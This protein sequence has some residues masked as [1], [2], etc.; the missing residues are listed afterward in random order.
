MSHLIPNLNRLSW[1]VLLVFVCVSGILA[2]S[3]VDRTVY[4]TEDLIIVPG[5]VTSEGFAGL[6]SVLMQEVDDDGLYQNFTEQNS[7]YWIFTPVN[8]GASPEDTPSE[9]VDEEPT[10]PTEEN[11]V[12]DPVLDGDAIEPVE[13]NADDNETDTESG[14]DN[15]NET[16]ATDSNTEPVSVNFS[17]PLPAATKF[18]LAQFDESTDLTD[19]MQDV[20][21]DEVQLDTI[22]D[23]PE[24]EVSSE[25]DESDLDSE[26]DTTDGEEVGSTTDSGAD[27]SITA[28]E[29]VDETD[30]QTP[31]VVDFGGQSCASVAGC[32]AKSLV[33]DG[34]ALPE[35]T[36]GSVLDTVQLR[37]SLAAKAR[38]GSPLQR[39]TVAY[40]IDGINYVPATVIDVDGEIANSINGDFYLVSIDVPPY[41]NDLSLL[42]VRLTYEGVEADIE[43][44]YVDGVWLEVTSGSFYEE[45]DF[46]SSSDAIAY[47]RDLAVP[48][49]NEM[50]TPNLDVVLGETPTFN[51]EYEM[52]KNFFRRIFNSLFGENTFSVKQVRVRHT[53]YGF[54]DVPYTVEYHEGKAW[55]LALPESPQKMHPGKYEVVVTIDE[56]DTE[57]TDS[58]E[59][60]WGVLAINSTKT[61]YTPGEE[62]TFNLAALTDQGDTICDANLILAITAPDNTFYDVPVTPSGACGENNV[63]DIP[64]YIASFINTEQIGLYKINLEHRNKNGEVVHKAQDSFAVMEFVPYDI[65]RTAPTRIYPLSPYNVNLKITANRTFDGDIVERVPRGFVVD[66]VSGDFTISTLPTFTE[67]RWS[68]VSLEEGEVLNLSYRFDAPDISPYLYILGPL[69]MDGFKELRAWQIASDALSG[70]GWFT[71]TRTVAGTNLNNTASPLQWST[72][73]VDTY[74]YTHSTTTNSERVTLRQSGDYFLAVTLP[75]QRTDANNSRTRVGVQVRVNGVAIPEGLGQSGYVRNANGHAE[76]SSHANFLLTNITA[77]DYV[78]VYAQGLTTI[79]AGDVVN[80]TSQAGLYLEYMAST[81]TVFAATTTRTV[82]STSLNTTASALQWSET[83]QDTGFVHSN[84]VNPENITLSDA[85]VYSVQIAV[86]LAGSAAQQ[87]VLGRVLLNGVEVNGGQFAQGYQQSAANENDAESS[88]HWSGI[89]VAT[90]TNQILSITVEQEAVAGTVLVP[91]GNVGSIFI[92]KMPATD[93]FVA[94]G[95][96][97]VG[98]IDWSPVATSSVQW[99]TELAT[100]STFTHS[101]TSNSHQITV[102]EAG[103]YL[104]TFNG[105][106]TQTAAARSNNRISVQVGGVDV[107]G[108]QVKSNYIRNQNGHGT[109]SSALTYLL[110]SLATSSVITVS[111]F[112]EANNT[113]VNDSTDAMIMLWK[114]TDFN[115]RPDEPTL[116]NVPFDNVRFASTTPYFEFMSSDSDGTSDLQYEFEI[117]TTSDFAT[118]TVR[119]SGVDAGF[120]NVVDGGDTSPFTEANQIRFQLQA[121]DALTDLNTYY[122]RVRAKDVNGSNTFGDWSTTQSLTVDLAASNPYW[123]Q[124]AD[125][126]FA[127]DTL[128]GALSSGNNA[129]VVDATDNTEMLIAYGEGTVT[130]PR[131]RLWNGTV[132]GT[133]GSAVAVGGTINWVETAAGVT[134]DEY[135]LVTLDGSNASYAQI[136]QASTTSWGNQVLLASGIT[137]PAYR[138]IAVAYES[139]SGDAMAISCGTGPDPVYRIWNGSSW[140]GTSTIN[141]SSLNNCNYVTVASDPA[142]DEIIVIVRD[143]GTQYEAFV[144]D[145][146]G[147]VESRV[148]GASNSITR[149]GMSVVYEAS[150]DQAI[151]LSTNGTANS[152]V[153]TTWNGTEWGTNTTQGVGNDFAEARLTAD[154]DSDEIILCYVDIDNDIGVLRWDGGVWATTFSELETTAN[155]ST[156]R[157]FDC[158]FETS[159]GRSTYAATIYSDNAGVR[160]RTATS[161]TWAAEANVSTVLDSFWVQTERADNGIIMTAALDDD[162]FDDLAVSY[163]NGSSWST[164]EVLETNPSSVIATPYEMFDMSAKRYQFTQGTV[165][166]QPIDFDFVPNQPTWGDVTFGST[167]PFGTEVLV[168]LK[169]TASTACDTYI[170]GAALAGN[171]TGFDATSLPINL[172]SLS[173]TTYNQICLEASITTLGSASAS[174]DD[175]ALSWV[176]EPKPIQSSFRW[177]TNLSALTPTDPWPLGVTDLSELAVI[178]ASVPV[179]DGD[180]LRLRM[181]LLGSNV[182]MPTTTEAFKLQ[183]AQTSSC[184]LSSTWQDVGTVGSTTALWRGYSNSVVGTDWYSASWSRRTR[185]SVNRTLVATTSPITD[186]PVYVNLDDLPA[187]F[188][189]NVQSDGDDIRITTS[190]GVTEVPYELVSISTASDNGELHFKAPTLSTT[191]DTVFYIY[192]GNSGASGYAASATYGSQ[193]V[194]TNNYRTRQALDDSPAASSPQFR[195][196]TS[197]SNDAVAYGDMLAGS[198]VA[199]KIGSGTVMTGNDGGTFESAFAFPGEFSLSMWWL[200]TG[201]GFAMAGP[202]GANEKM[203]PWNTPAGQV[204]TRVLTTSDTSVVHPADGTWTHVVLTRDSANKVDLYLNGVRSRLYSDVAQSGVSDWINFGGDPTQGFIGTLDELR[205]ATGTRT[206][207]WVTTEYNNQ[208]NATG[209]YTIATEELIGDNRPL[210]STVL[211]NSDR[212]ETYEENNPTGQNNYAL[213]VDQESEWDFV[214]E[215]NG[216]SANTQYCFRLVYSDGAVLSDYLDY[217]LLVTNAPPQAPD[218]SAPFDNEQM[219][220]TSPWFE[221]SAADEAGDDVSYEIEIDD[222]YAFASPNITGDSNASFA[223]F[224]NVINPSERSVYSDGQTVRFVP[225][226]ALTTGVTYYWRVRAIDNDGSNT[227][228]LWSSVRSFTVNTGTTITTWYQTTGEQF[229]TNSHDNTVVSTS[230]DDVRIATSLT[231]GTTT[232]SVI[233]YDDR[234]TGNAWGSFSFSHNV[235]SGSIRYYVEYQV[236]SGEFALVPDT[237]LSGNSSGFTSSPISLAT[238]NPDTY[239]ELRLVAVL[240]GNDSLPRLLDW[241]VTWGLTIE[242]PA[243]SVPFD[244]AKVS[245]TTPTFNFVTSDPEGQDLEYEVQISSDSDF[246]SSSTFLSGVDAGFVNSENSG[247]TSPFTTNQVIAYTVQ[248]P[249]TNG[250]TYWWRARA[251]DPAGSNTW[252]D[253]SVPTSFTVDTAITTSVWYQTTGDQF[254]TDGLTDIE[255]TA[256]GAQITSVVRGM[257]MAYGEGTGQ[258]PR[259]RIFDGTQ[260]GAAETAESIGSTIRWT[261]LK[262][263][264][265][266]PEYALATIGSD[267]DSNVQIYD[268]S[269]DV[270]GNVKELDDTIADVSKKGIALSYESDSGDLLAVSCDG[271]D[272]VYSIWNGT[273][274]TA[275]TSLNLTN[276]NN[277]NWVEMASDPTSDEIVAVFR[278]TNAGANDAEA[279]VWSGSGWGNNLAYS[280]QEQDAY[281]GIAVAYEESGGQAVVVGANNAGLNLVYSTWN[282]T[283][284]LA[285]STA[286]GTVALGDHIEWASL[287]P[288][289]G[290][291]NIALC[292]IDNDSD[293]GIVQWNG[294]G[295]GTATELEQLG[296]SNAG[297]A[298]DCEYETLGSRDGYLMVP[299]SDNGALGAGDGGKYQFASSTPS[300]ELDLGTIED[301]WRVLARRS[302]D[303]TIH[304]VFFDDGN[305]RWQAT[306]FDGS[307]WAAT[308]LTI[309]NPPTTGTPFDGYLSMAAQIY[310][311][312]TEGAIRGT[313]IDFDDGTGPRW[314]RFTWTDS[315]PGLSDIKYRLYYLAS[316]SVYTLVPDSVLSGNAAGFSTSPVSIASLDRTIY[317]NL[318]L[319]AELICAAG[320]CPSVSDWSLEWSEGII[321]SGRAYEY[322]GVSSTTSGTVGVVVN[323]VLQSGKT[324]TI[325]PDGTWSISNVTAFADDTVMVFVDGATESDESLAIATYDGVGDVTNLELTK[326]H[327]TI[328]SSDTATTTNA[329]MVGYDVTSD[330]DIFLDVL[331]GGAFDLCSEGCADHRLKIKSGARYQPFANITTHDLLNY[332]SLYLGT[333]TMRVRGSWSDQATTSVDTSTVIFT[334]TSSSETLV[335]AT[336]SV[337]FY[338]VTFGETS[339]AATFTPDRTVDVD[340]TFSVQY[341]TYA[342]GTSSLTVARDVTLGASANISGLGTTTFDGSGSFTWSD[343]KASSSNLGYVVI[344]GTTK[345]INLGSEVKAQ[346]ITIGS[347]DTLNASGSGYNLQVIQH[348]TNNNLFVPQSGT[349]TFMG[350]TTG[351][352]S[353]G[354]SAF[355]NLTFSGAGAVWSF[356]TSTLAVNGHLTIATGTVTLPTGTTTIG[357]S[358]LNTGGN[359]AHNNGEVRM[360]S[361]A[362]GRLVTTSGTNF[363][364]G[365]YDLVFT[366]SGAWSFTG[367]ATTSRDM[368]I[369]GGSVTMPATTMTIGGDFAVSGSGSFVHNSGEVIF[370]VQGN[371]TLS[372]NGSS[373]NNVRVRG[374]SGGGWYNN[375][376]QYRVPVTIYESQVDGDLV[377]FPVYVDLDNLPAGFFT[378]VAANGADIR[379]TD[380]TGLTELPLEVVTVSTTTTS[381][382]LYF[383]ANNISATTDTT[384][385]IYYGNPSASAYAVT[386]TYGARNVWSASYVLVSHLGDLTTSTIH[387][388]ASTTNGTKTSA[389]NPLVSTAGKIYSAQD[390]SA[391]LVQYTSGMLQ[392]ANQYSVSMWFKPD[393]LTGGN[394]DEQTYGRSLYGISASGAPYQWLRVGGTTNPTELTLC[395]YDSGTA[396]NVT[397]GAGLATGNWYFVSV[398]AVKSSSTT[399]RLNGVQRLSFTNPGSGNV[400]ANFTIGDLRGTPQR[401]INFDGLIDEVRVANATRTTAWRDAEYKN[402]ATSTDFYA[403]STVE[404]RLSRI[405]SDTTTTILGNYISEA[406]GEATFPT[407][408]L[409]IGGSF[410]NNALFSANGG[411]V[412]FNSTSGSETIAVGS[413]TFAT[414]EFNATSGDFTIVESATSTVAISLTNA[415]Q[416]T[417]QSGLSLTASGTYS[418]SINGASTTWTGSVLRLVGADGSLNTKT[419][420]GDTYGTLETWGDTDVTLWNSSAL[421][422]VTASTSSIYLA[423]H[424]SVD[425]DLTIYG[426]YV[427]QTGTEYW[428]YATDF[429]GTALG[430]SSVRQVDVRV[431]TGSTIGFANASL[432]ITGSAG[433][434]TTIA[435]LTGNFSLNASNTTITAQYFT[436]AGTGNSGFGLKASST[437]STFS[438]A[439]FTVDTG[440]TAITLEGT[441]INQNPAK[442]LERVAFATTTGAASNVTFMGTSTS[443][444]WFK[445]G[446]GNLYGEAFDAN[447]ANPGVVRFDDSSYLITVAGRILTSDGSTHLGSPVCDGATPNVRVVVNS[448]SYTASTTCNAST[449]AYNFSNV[450]FT[451]DPTITVYLNTN[452]GAVGSVVT[453]T[454]TADITNLDV[455]ANQVTLRHEGAAVMTI[456]NLTNFDYASDTDM[457]F[458]ATTTPS[459]TLTVY[460]GSGLY[461]VAS[462]TFTPGGNV[463]LS[464]NAST[465]ANEGTLQLATST[466]FIAAGTETHTLAGRLV[467]GAN[468]TVTTASSTFVFNASSTGKSITAT[469]NIS[470][471]HLSFTGVGGAWH[472][473]APITVAG[474]MTVATGTVTGVNNITISNGSLTGDGTLSLG[475]GTTT[476]AVTNTLGG[477]R[478][479]TFYNLVLGS[480]SVVGTTTPASSATTTVSGR[481]TISAAHTLALGSG[482]LDL[483][484][485]GTVFVNSGTFGSGTSL[486]RYSGAGANVLSTTYYDLHLAAAA[487]SSTYTAT[488]AGILLNRNLTIGNGTASSTFTTLSNDPLLTVAGNV[489]VQASGTLSLSDSATTTISGSYDNDGTLLSNGGK[490]LFNGSGSTNIAAGNSTFANVTI[491]GTGAFS[492][493]ESATATASFILQNH[494]T[495]TLAGTASLAV[496]GQFTNTLAGATT[497]FLGTLHLYGG[498]SLSI[499]DKSTADTYATL[500]VASGTKVRMWNSSASSYVINGGLYSQDHANTNG[501][502]NIYGTFN[503]TSATDHWSYATDFDGTVLTSGNERAVTVALAS[504]ASV[505]WTGGALNVVG[506]SSASTTITNQGSGNYSLQIGGTAATRFNYVVIR[507]IDASGLVFTGTPTVNDFSR[508][509]HLVK[510]NSGTAVTVGGSA[511]NANEAKNFTGNIFA[512]DVGVLTP[513]N[514]TATGSAITSWRFTN[515]SGNLA[516]EASDIDPAGDPGYVVWDDSAAL[517]TVSGNVY[518]DEGVGTSTV[519][520]GVTANIKLVVAGLTTY[521]TSCNAT[522]SAY[523]ISGVA[524]NS[525]DSLVLFIDGE[526]VQAAHV[527]KSP[528]SSI[529][530][531]HLYENRVIVRHENTDPITIADMAVYDS[532]DDADIPFTAVDASPDTLTL[533]ANYKLLIWTNKTFAPNGNV[534]ITGGGAGASYDGTLEALAGARFKASGNEVHTIGGS[535]QFGAGAVFEAGQSTTTFTTTGAARTIDVNEGA[536]YNLSFTGSGSWVISDNNFTASSSF[537]QSAGTVTFGSGTTTIG[538]SFNATGGNFSMPGS[539]LVFISTSTGNIVRFD[540]ATVPSLY[541][542]GNSGSFT[543]TDNNA[544]TSGSFIIRAASTVTL[545]PG[546]LALSGSFVNASGTIVHNTSDLY[547]TGSG[548]LTLQ[549]NNSDLYAL[550]KTGNATLTIVDSSITF[551]DDLA[552]AS[553]TLITATGTT[554]VGGSFTVTDGY[555]NHSTGTVLFNAVAVGKNIS[556]STSPFYNVNFGSASGGWTIGSNATVTNHLTLTTAS[557]FT[558]SPGI[559]V[560]VGGVFTNLVGGAPTTWTGSTLSLTSTSSYTINTKVSGGD[561]YATLVIPTTDIRMWNSTVATTSLGTTASVYSQDH[562]AVDGALNIYG[563]FRIATTTEYWSYASDFDG[564]VLS[565]GSRR[566]VT[567]RHDHNATTTLESGSLNIV[568]AVGATS[569]LRNNATGTYSIAITGGT[570][571]AQYYSVASMTANGLEISGAPTISDLSNGYF[572]LG[573]NTGRLITLASTSL[574]ANASKIFTNIG[575]TSTLGYS[576]TNVYLSGSTSNAWRFNTTYGTLA[577]EAY[578]FDGI[579][580]CGSLRFDDSAC[581]LTSQSAYR[582]RSDDGGEGAPASEWYDTSFDFR[583]RVRIYN[584]SATSYATTA[585]PMTVVY[586]SAMQADFDDIRFTED[587]GLSPLDF[588]IEK[589]TASTEAIAWVEVPS[590]AASNYTTVFMYFGSSTATSSS[591][592]TNTFARID[593]FEDNNITE[594]SGDTGLFQTDTTPVF[595]GSYALEAL[596]K[597]GRT[598]D[599]IFRVAETISQGQIVHWR[600]YIDT[601]AGASDEACTIFGVQSPGT[602]NNNYAVCLEQFGTD[603]IT[604]AKNVSD[605]DS[606]G[607]T[608]LG[609]T[610]VTYSTGWYE[611]YVDWQTSNRLDVSLYNAAGTLVATTSATDSSYTSGGY[612]FTFWF[613]NGSWDNLKAYNRGPIKPTVYFG[614]KQTDGGATWLAAQ[615][616]MSSAIPGTTRR[617][618]I[619]VENTGLDVT[620]QQYR[621]QFAPKGAAPSCEAVSSGSFAAV[622]NQASC[623]TSAICMQ[624]S[625]NLVDADPAT[626]HLIDLAGTFTSGNVVESPS[627]M[628]SAIDV[629]QD[630]Y[631]ELEYVITPTSNASDAYCF[632]VVNDSTALDYYGA[633]AE[634]GLQFDPTLG[635]VSF[636]QGLPITLTPNATTTIYAT[637]TVTDFNGY[638]DITKATTTIYRSGV[639]PTCTADNNNCY[640][641]TTGNSTCNFG[642]CSGNTCVLSCAA[643]IY[644]HAD[645][646]DAGTYEG[647]EWLAYME[648]EDAGGAYDFASALGIE[649][650]TLRA[651]TVDSAINYGALEPSANTE[652]YNPT[653][654]ISNI[655][656]VLFDIEILGTDLSGGASTIPADQQK[657]A[658]STFTYGSCTTCSLLSS[659]TPIDLAVALAKPTSTTLPEAPIYWG[660]AVPY[661]VASVAH[662][663]TNVFTPVS[664]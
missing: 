553:G 206:T 432:N 127:G 600:Q 94:R 77:D 571:N 190:D 156:A 220:S 338:N 408:V 465:S 139:Q 508:T 300:G 213:E 56:N 602:S 382:E 397:S 609:S 356:S 79:D 539:A 402:M 622:P 592:G 461:I 330:E 141:A 269:V 195:D 104:L 192:Y 247:D 87:N 9:N 129:V 176:R 245:T 643:D 320:L 224:T 487:A 130:T 644:F 214:L 656:N 131:Y 526:A 256:G 1:R 126:Q 66:E 51:F 295:F 187:T 283:S 246:V 413:S 140:T 137:G 340:G 638:A 657:F 205:V 239:N 523:S 138:G 373:F 29:V 442:Q 65:E 611:V 83:R 74:Y 353:R 44:V 212:A 242:E 647:Q 482:Q 189:D 233:D 410:D 355:N 96:N 581:L 637:T 253:Y 572:D 41:T 566:A 628:T 625:T 651:L 210:P 559:N 103:S 557:S 359:F 75:Q 510:I 40:A 136:Y 577:G 422:Y 372:T 296:N 221:F 426:N 405:F 60:Y 308:P 489:L 124:T 599:G 618:R 552:I 284:W 147:W 16:P 456:A 55:T 441:T 7:A 636:N 312:F 610:T 62:V 81:E 458:S 250:L 174:L 114:K 501:L 558:V 484:G 197:Y 589:T 199:G 603:R 494:S 93:V 616:T 317:S 453:K 303:G 76:S 574:D 289:V 430:T 541:F 19:A 179:N 640:I 570:F 268:D 316:T 597:S 331:S 6:E 352:I 57:Y 158:E 626:D 546:V 324:G 285:T 568:G 186:F 240:S 203:G 445:S 281:Q 529:S 582:W 67:I 216:V 170:P 645:P 401:N 654:T 270:W 3:Y 399:V 61:M 593:D 185:I 452:G 630:H 313:A 345:T 642:S 513:S 167:E 243:H 328:G 26:S 297:Q 531:M 301:S 38:E 274:W 376:W 414:L 429:D 479:W 223:E 427:R 225:T 251:R 112:E 383:R 15:I 585:I 364:N 288:D 28:T 351:T 398:E 380:S 107:P 118:S 378:G 299:Y 437:L 173:T 368:R 151:V 407:G 477:V 218:L 605:N 23:E 540:D 411:T 191:T 332:G 348:W 425:G 391:D 32:V 416:F 260:W 115:A 43:K 161:T 591:S 607:A 109:S 587:D 576:G 390:H 481:L 417:L 395:A 509:D 181:S 209:F 497:D 98:G 483:A 238:V 311:N 519:C 433:A 287:K 360:T 162:A 91:A 175:W 543:M 564:T 17:L 615:N 632:R 606:T 307:S 440:A 230:S 235:T 562:G 159:A 393:A 113:T 116:Y 232:S 304:A 106:F 149:E 560:L 648:V 547:L 621:L 160:Y 290:T 237:A 111:T 27:D 384:F 135:T 164:P 663:G 374:G 215:A 548:A 404:N 20:A 42:K 128:V 385:Y 428:S 664:P 277:C 8:D 12:T 271:T 659:S 249:L 502:L 259:Y 184:S 578:D 293:I 198:V 617:L 36:P 148:L 318:Q 388:S 588:W 33:F 234:D 652:A 512:Y 362:S 145:G 282:G 68:N 412:R 117:S 132:W 419:H 45:A 5:N 586:D 434:S 446:Y 409:S 14:A 31:A 439:Y 168:R 208:S 227:A 357:G 322:D 565:G 154:T 533:P 443:F 254:D 343:A 514:V 403:V 48:N 264:P 646:T 80:V 315:T 641:L 631:T 468:A 279:W 498:T 342:R 329:N 537:V 504:G 480:G 231:L 371:D 415:A 275:T 473:T 594:Y 463:T 177:Y 653:T 573:V 623:G 596:N 649:L 500:S 21:N 244:N 337:R 182:S 556:A 321:V 534:T 436:V 108:A 229:D 554:A 241:T 520:D 620:G 549:A 424:A 455:Y 525:L 490:I 119:T 457:R 54:L 166:S 366:G 100:S 52:Q 24:T 580:A 464:G 544:T 196:S 2:Y 180:I 262:A 545:P 153:Y 358:F 86:P 661:G 89:V 517:V 88:I 146:T 34:F 90:T 157:N 150:G 367:A 528:I 123:F 536:F 377:N 389:N 165:L 10:L 272:A 349:V 454:P 134:R 493:T 518:S 211:T 339:G 575:F 346:T 662:Q 542:T 629:D 292:Y 478:P 522:S 503:E 102:T 99:D 470:F 466:Q 193:N 291:D 202:T 172:S 73:S 178:N 488:G 4:Q 550:R 122:W 323:G 369:T 47:E 492:V 379:V 276:T 423:D 579:D 125:G 39:F 169:Y 507:E 370:L 267:Q 418:Q 567:V 22:I 59:F 305:D 506:T 325:L 336:S 92:Q 555:F 627:N 471:H 63:T 335:A 327:L 363:L 530:N 634:L 604:L 421:S 469:N 72:S 97:L 474:T 105:A 133:E 595:G 612:G 451:G 64:D 273:S 624:T 278:H 435:A 375:S 70:I 314:E 527:T 524:Y 252:S 110:T 50:T 462:S 334:A 584:D 438:D 183:Y 222:D 365:F 515:H 472:L 633:V 280:E 650:L 310:P 121:A 619:A 152:F 155:G 101:T 204:F 326:R 495:F 361:T 521:T 406:G 583:K 459:T 188:F 144:W 639:G 450:A 13:T 294:S 608:R 551:R 598:T 37:L 535:F 563:D 46:A 486:V 396:C 386:D 614:A 309:T 228:G 635:T 613:Q 171:D 120:S 354:T 142:S 258:A 532:S 449:G 601:S 201:D 655:G 248:S 538:R 255:T 35:F 302:A 58:F 516:G 266:R 53:T 447:D 194:W 306:W 491:N 95:R 344:D 394:A 219:A 263:A 347:D 257:M 431:A 561:D 485:S 226:S 265:T 84:T 460:P 387:N 207:A 511:L 475:G 420:S 69:D 82:A 569:S 11:V 496:A 392:N 319:D 143:T 25:V 18:P 217:P 85:G 49:L 30:T 71:G 590:V 448:G 476:L 298:V 78:E 467:L 163:W 200:A 381:G 658:T 333:S 350:T 499:N 236:T 400:S 505:S 286:T 660:I 444:V 261:E 341:G